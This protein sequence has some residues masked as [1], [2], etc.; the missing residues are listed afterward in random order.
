[1]KKLSSLT[2]FFPVFNEEKNIPHFVSEALTEL[3]KI[4]KK[5]EI[6][7]INDGSKDTSA[8]VADVLAKKHPDIVRVLHHE[9]NK[10]YGAAL[11]SGFTNARYDWVFFTDGDLQFTLKQLE[12]FVPYTDEYKV[13]IGHRVERAEGALRAIPARLYKLFV[14]V[15][16]RVHVIDIDCAFKLFETKL[17]QSLQL[18]SNGAFISSE[19][20]Y[21]L[22]KRRVKFKQLPVKHQKRRFGKPTGN[23]MHVIIRAGLE[24]LRLYLHM[25]FGWF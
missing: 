20:L 9:K 5:F 17:I 10:G 11:R 12:K 13:I 14:D 24:A 16:F 21:R 6:L 1:M 8:A 23:R 7:I 4:A 2:A 15:L 18:E 3:P 22:K 19:F 25:K